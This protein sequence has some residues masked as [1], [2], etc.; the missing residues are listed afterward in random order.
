MRQR[1]SARGFTLQA[2]AEWLRKN[3]AQAAAGI[4]RSANQA[5]AGE[6]SFPGTHKKPLFA[7]NP[8][9]VV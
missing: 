8:P 7:G 3:D 2:E 9:K 4:V 6:F 1:Q 5:L